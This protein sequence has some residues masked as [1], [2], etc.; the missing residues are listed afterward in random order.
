MAAT[1]INTN[2]VVVW[3]GATAATQLAVGIVSLAVLH[4]FSMWVLFIVGTP[5]YTVACMLA[6]ANWWIHKELQDPKALI[7]DTFTEDI[8]RAVS[9]AAVTVSIIILLQIVI[10]VSLQAYQKRNVSHISTS[11]CMVQ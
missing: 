4:A 3:A 9:S 8:E 2:V 5:N 7:V 1:A 6:W 11:D 10:R